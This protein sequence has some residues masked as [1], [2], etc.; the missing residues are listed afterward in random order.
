[1]IHKIISFVLLLSVGPLGCIGDQQSNLNKWN[2]HSIGYTNELYLM[3][4]DDRYG[5]W[6]GNTFF[7][8]IYREHET[9]QILMDYTEYEGREGPR[10]PPNPDSIPSTILEWLEQEPIVTKKTRIKVSAK[11][12]RL[13]ADAIQE[14]IELRVNNDQFVAMSGVVNSVIYSDSSLVVKD[15]PSTDWEGFQIIRNEIEK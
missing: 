12:Q 5:E 6:G 13:I 1:M 9:K 15:Y 8:K 7:L 14:L 4:T 2:Y 11:Y 3:Q 10:Q